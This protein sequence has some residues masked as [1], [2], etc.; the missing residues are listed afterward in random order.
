[1]TD[2]QHPV[3]ADDISPLAALVKI[4]AI[5]A[6]GAWAFVVLAFFAAANAP[7]GGGLG[8]LGPLLVLIVTTPIFFVFVLPALLFSFLG[9]ESGAKVGGVLLLLGAAAGVFFLGAPMWR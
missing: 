3:P 2:T 9:G 1:M 4:G 8:A 5:L 7:G 6:T